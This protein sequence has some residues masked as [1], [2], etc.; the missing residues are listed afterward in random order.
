MEHV[1]AGLHVLPNKNDFSLRGALTE[2]QH[3]KEH[4]KIRTF[5]NHIFKP[6]SFLKYIL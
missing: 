1:D 6:I 4:L 2:Y 3:S 5:V